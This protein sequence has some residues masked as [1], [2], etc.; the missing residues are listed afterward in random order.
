MKILG[1]IG[2]FI[3]IFILY[4]AVHLVAHKLYYSI[5]Y[6]DLL[7]SLTNIFY[8]L[9]ALSWGV[10]NIY[11]ESAQEWLYI[12]LGLVVVTGII[13]LSFSRKGD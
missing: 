12:I 7:G 6:H 8:L 2:I 11:W 13:T 9:S 5:L 3:E 1:Y 10:L 4:Y